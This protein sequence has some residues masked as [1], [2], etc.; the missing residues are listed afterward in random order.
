M[1]LHA[2][3]NRNDQFTMNIDDATAWLGAADN[4]LDV[5]RLATAACQRPRDPGAQRV[6]RPRGRGP[7]SRPRS[8]RSGQSRRFANTQYAGRP[9]FG[10]TASG[11][12]A[13]PADGTY[14]GVSTPV[15]RTIA[16]GQ[17]IQVNVNGDD[18]FGTPGNDLFTTARPDL[19]R[20]A[21]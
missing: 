21:F 15:E 20:G 14:V 9:V 17:R 16:P 10:G 18:V 12:V 13:Y 7:V 11:G 1:A 2:S 5:G 8:T 19:G 3:L 6:E 4:V